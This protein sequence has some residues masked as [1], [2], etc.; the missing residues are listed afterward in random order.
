MGGSGYI[1]V[2]RAW[3]WVAR[4]PVLRYVEYDLFDTKFLLRRSLL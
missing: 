1:G 2:R 4:M 3:V